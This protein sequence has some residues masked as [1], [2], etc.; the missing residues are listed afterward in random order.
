MR[1]LDVAIVGAGAAG[2]GAAKAAA[3]KGLSFKVLE[4][5]KF[6]GGRARTDTTS[7]GVPYDLGCRVM[8]GG[9]SNPFVAYARKTGAR[10]GPSP[11]ATKYHDG[12]DFLDA[13]ATQAAD[14][15]YADFETSV[16]AAH[17]ACDPTT[18][19]AS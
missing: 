9:S 16:L 19:S 11:E 5:A 7:L 13:E 10:T 17:L 18:D 14:G 15:A 2:L 8:Y 6:A 3:L 1:M 4:A 12:A